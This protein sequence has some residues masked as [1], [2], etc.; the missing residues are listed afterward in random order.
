M[1]KP[2]LLS[3]TLVPPLVQLDSA[4]QFLHIK[5]QINEQ[6]NLLKKILHFQNFYT[7]KKNSKIFLNHLNNLFIDLRTVCK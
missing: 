1:F 7:F 2:F 4:T 5:T 6:N 3:L